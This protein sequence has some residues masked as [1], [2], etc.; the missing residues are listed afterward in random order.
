MTPFA[1]GNN[2]KTEA[3]ESAAAYVVICDI[4]N[5]TELTVKCECNSR[6]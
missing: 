2:K 6:K 1:I 5:P 4:T 3:A